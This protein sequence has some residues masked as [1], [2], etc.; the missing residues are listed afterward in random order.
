MNKIIYFF[1]YIYDPTTIRRND[2]VSNIETIL[3]LES[4]LSNV[5]DAEK[6]E[7]LLETITDLKRKEKLM[8]VYCKNTKIGYLSYEED[9]VTWWFI[10]GKNKT[11]VGFDDDELRVWAAREGYTLR[12]G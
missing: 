3:R 12:H 2:K 5:L 9:I 11:E 10:Q 8:E 4:R 7:A 1:V 6:R